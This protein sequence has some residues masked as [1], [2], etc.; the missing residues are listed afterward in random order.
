[1]DGTGILIMLIGAGV[2]CIAF[3]FYQDPPKRANLRAKSTRTRSKSA[4]NKRRGGRTHTGRG[5][6][7]SRVGSGRKS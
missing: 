7:K 5:A 3:Q 6:S 4:Q 2:I 1:M